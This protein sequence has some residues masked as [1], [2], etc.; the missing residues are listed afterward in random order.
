MLPT[1]ACAS[2]VNIANGTCQKKWC[3][4]KDYAGAQTRWRCCHTRWSPLS[5][6]SRKVK[7]CEITEEH[8]AFSIESLAQQ[9]YAICLLSNV[10]ELG[11]VQPVADCRGVI[12][13]LPKCLACHQI[14]RWFVPSS[15]CQPQH[16][17]GA[18]G[19]TSIRIGTVIGKVKEGHLVSRNANCPTNCPTVLQGSQ[20]E[21][22]WKIV[23]AQQR[24]SAAQAPS[25]SPSEN[26]PQ[27][28][29]STMINVSLSLVDSSKEIL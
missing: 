23:K 14:K 28:K 15:E 27:Q 26:I 17:I 8:S 9:F 6:Q 12:G 4:C 1:T 20:R 16:S 24:S 10:N 22:A 19:P 11:G 13:S 25:L 5:L 3:K 29:G 7:P 2:I 21:Y 18:H